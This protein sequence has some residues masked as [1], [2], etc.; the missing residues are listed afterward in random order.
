MQ[1]RHAV[2]GVWL[3]A[4]RET[5]HAEL[6]LGADL[7]QRGIRS[8]ATRE[9]VSQ[10]SDRMPALGLSDGKIKNVTENSTNGRADSVQNAQRGVGCFGHRQNKRSATTTV[11]PGFRSVP[12][13]TTA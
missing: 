11:S 12:G 13:G 4:D 8:P 5:I 1:G 7:F 3:A 10:Y 2:D 6:E 9:A